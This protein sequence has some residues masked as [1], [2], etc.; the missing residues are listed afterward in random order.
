MSYN[1]KMVDDF[2]DSFKVFTQTIDNRVYI[3]G[4]DDGVVD[5][6]LTLKGARKLAKHLKRAALIAEFER[7][8]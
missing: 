4:E 8:E 3:L 5:L 2:D 1:A 7:K 6:G